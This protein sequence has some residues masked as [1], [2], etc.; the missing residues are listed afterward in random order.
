MTI[1]AAIIAD[2]IPLGCVPTNPAGPSC[3]GP[4]AW[5]LTTWVLT[6]PRFLHA[7]LMTH[8]QLSRNA[9]SSRAI[10]VEKQLRR[11]A[12][13]PAMPVSWGLNKPGMQAA[14]VLTPENEALARAAWLEARDAAIG[15]SN[16][17][18]SLRVHKQITNRVAEPWSHI[19]VVVSATEW[20][21][22]FT[23]RHHPDAQPEF[24]ALAALMAEAYRARVPD[25]LCDGAWHLPFVGLDGDLAQ[26][27][28]PTRIK[29]SVARCAR[30][31]YLNHD[32]TQPDVVKD[33]ELHD[34]LVAG[35]PAHASPSEHQATPFTRDKHGDWAYPHDLKWDHEL[36]RLD[37]GTPWSANYRGFYQY[38]QSL[39]GQNAVTFPWGDQ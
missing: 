6:Y 38:R 22:F 21:N 18:A 30:V 25:I 36:G 27:D 15:Y 10:P 17:L 33:I 7:E 16:R 2:S 14:E 11:I 28:L 32:G 19:T 8:R 29:C 20:A 1:S 12:D 39:R 37:K 9:S 31:S 4:K 26:L 3:L 24:Q 13:D 35:K 23:L 34:R 5:R